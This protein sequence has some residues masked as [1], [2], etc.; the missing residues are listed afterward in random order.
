M[1]LSSTRHV[2]K[3]SEKGRGHRLSKTCP[4]RAASSASSAEVLPRGVGVWLIPFCL[5]SVGAFGCDCKAIHPAEQPSLHNRIR[6]HSVDFPSLQPEM[7]VRTSRASRS[8]MACI[9]P[10]LLD[11]PALAHQRHGRDTRRRGSVL[12]QQS[13]PATLRK[14]SV[15]GILALDGKLFHRGGVCPEA[16]R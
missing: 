5:S 8:H 2:A 14:S 11:D 9:C 16:V 10:I 7:V 4:S 1:S 3:V 12:C 6:S 13:P 15:S